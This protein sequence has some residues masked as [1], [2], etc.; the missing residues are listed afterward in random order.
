VIKDF[1]PGK[2]LYAA[3][4]DAMS[5]KEMVRIIAGT[6]NKKGR[7]MPIPAKPVYWLLKLIEKAGVHAGISSEQVAHMS[8]NLTAEMAEPLELYPVPMKSFEEHMADI[9]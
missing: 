2:T 8:E 5:F 1:K 4:R 7:I 3:G 9:K 6:R